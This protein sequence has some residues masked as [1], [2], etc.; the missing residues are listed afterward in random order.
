MWTSLERW[1]LLGVAT[2][3]STTTFVGNATFN[4]SIIF[5]GATAD[6]NETTLTSLIQR[7]IARSRCLMQRQLLLVL[8]LLR[9]LQRH[10]VERCFFDRCSH[11]AVDLIAWA[12]TSR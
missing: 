1:T 10:S 7:L 6:A 2:F 12:T 3:D 5:E 9:A 4:G 8:L 11:I